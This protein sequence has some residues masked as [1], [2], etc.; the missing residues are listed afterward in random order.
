WEA[1]LH[2]REV[3]LADW[4]RLN[5]QNKLDLMWRSTSAFWDALWMQTYR[6]ED[7]MIQDLR[8]GL[9]LLLKNKSFTTVAILSLAL[10]IGANTAIFQ[11]LDATL[12]RMLPIKAPQELVEVRLADTKGVRG[13]GN[14]WPVAL[15]YP[16]WEQIR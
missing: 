6:L 5:R 9:R 7:A 3:L 2:H 16:I 14:R 11:L 1:E 8:Y 4:D 12:R 15:T 13:G 10:G